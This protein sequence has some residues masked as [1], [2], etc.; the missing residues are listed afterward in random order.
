MRALL[1]VGL[2]VLL[3]LAGCTGGGADAASQP[4]TETASAT[5]CTPTATTETPTPTPTATLTPTATPTRT[6]TSTATPTPSIASESAW[7]VH[8]LD[9]VDGDT[10]TVRFANG[11]IE[12]VSLLGID[13][14]ETAGATDPSMYEGVP[15]TEAGR[16]WLAEWGTEAAVELSARIIGET[17]TIR[18]DPAADRRAASGELLVYVDTGDAKTLNERLLD[19]GLAR[20]TERDFSSRDAFAAAEQTAQDSDVGLWNYTSANTETSTATPTGDDD[21]VACEGVE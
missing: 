20:L 5:E 8:V 13:A 19:Q 2:A 10:I 18:T 14:P 1:T 12:N 21:G 15:D 3:V 6:E 16:E 4:T 9:V 7:A 11:T 17:H